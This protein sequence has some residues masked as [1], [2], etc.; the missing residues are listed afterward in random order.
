MEGWVS[1]NL[2]WYFS[3]LII[4][5]LP[6]RSKFIFKYPLSDNGLESSCISHLQYAM[7]AKVL[8]EH[9]RRK[10]HLFLVIVSCIL[11][12]LAR[13]AWSIS[14]VHAWEH[15]VE[16]FPRAIPEHLGP[17]WLHSRGWGQVMILPWFSWRKYGTPSSDVPN[18][19]ACFLTI[20]GLPVHWRVFFCMASDCVPALIRET[21]R[22]LCHSSGCNKHLIQWN[23]KPNLR[24][25]DSSLIVPPWALSLSPAV[26][27]RDISIS[28][29]L[30]SSHS[31]IILQLN[32]SFQLLCGFC[33]L[34]GPRLMS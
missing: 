33:L 15:P 34:I 25:G 7:M 30:I 29:Y 5:L 11:L 6:L 3:L 17:Q 26:P 23:F 8:G 13:V 20:L 10:G 24:E 32:F 2:F 27:F 31:L 4:N 14:R 19:S 16:L 28:F 1:L 21:Q 9:C 12:F 18:P 22:I